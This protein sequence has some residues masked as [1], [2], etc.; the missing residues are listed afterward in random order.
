MT[1]TEATSAAAPAAA[2]DIKEKIEM[3]KT[4]K[5]RGNECL[6]TNKKSGFQDALGF[7]TQALEIGSFDNELNSQVYSNRAHVNLML[8]NFVEA[9]DDCRKGITANAANVKCYWRAGRASLALDLYEQAKTFVQDG[10]KIDKDN[11]ELKNL[12]VQC[13][14]KLAAQ[15]KAK[16][17][18]DCTPQEAQEQKDRVDD[19]GEKV[20]LLHNQVGMND[21]ETKRCQLTLNSLNEIAEDVNLFKPVGRTFLL[22]DRPKFKDGL[23]KE[24][25][26][27]QK[28][29]PKLKKNREEMAN[30]RQT[31]E[32]DLQEMMLG[33]KRNQEKVEAEAR[34]KMEA[35][36]RGE[37]KA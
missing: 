31:A 9:V 19:L 22:Q 33:L 34:S 10:M 27:L 30:R 20:M 15:M 36:Q 28:S 29:A 4:L 8:N 14:K 12:H 5:Q 24:I 23:E 26:D 11:S 7:Y 32:K 25:N 13:Q 6:Q 21:R 2:T 3:Q 37:I 16:R 35:Q 18:I 1:A 17:G